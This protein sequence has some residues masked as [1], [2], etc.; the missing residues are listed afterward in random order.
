MKLA[1]DKRWTPVR[2][3]KLE[4]SLAQNEGLFDAAAPVADA[5]FSAPLRAATARFRKRIAYALSRAELKRCEALPA[6]WTFFGRCAGEQ[7]RCVGR[8]GCIV[9]FIWCGR[10]SIKQT[11]LRLLAIARKSGDFDDNRGCGYSHASF[12]R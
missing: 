4:A 8:E 7:L 12:A 6:H 1:E 3:R 11:L 9:V 2:L 5:G 10:S